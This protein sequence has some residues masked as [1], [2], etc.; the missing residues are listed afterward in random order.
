MALYN[1][2]FRR[3]VVFGLVWI[4]GVMGFLAAWTILSAQRDRAL[5]TGPAFTAVTLPGGLWTL[6]GPPTLLMLA[7]VAA[8]RA[9]PAS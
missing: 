9:R 3:V 8:R 6:L 5:H 7:W 2:R 4:V 1:W